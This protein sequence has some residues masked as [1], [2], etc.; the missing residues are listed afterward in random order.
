MLEAGAAS[1]DLVFVDTKALTGAVRRKISDRF[2]LA[3]GATWRS[4]E[5]PI[6]GVSSRT[7]Q[8]EDGLGAFMEI[9]FRL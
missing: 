4:Q 6:G 1:D 9:G 8:K 5:A 2:T 3:G 7:G